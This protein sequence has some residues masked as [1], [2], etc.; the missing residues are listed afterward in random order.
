MCSLDTVLGAW[1]RLGALATASSY[2]QYNLICQEGFLSRVIVTSV[3]VRK[4]GWKVKEEAT[5]L[6]P[7]SRVAEL[8]RRVMVFERDYIVFCFP[9]RG[10]KTL[11]C[12]CSIWFQSRRR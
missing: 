8:R 12:Q 3:P 6:V 1:V 9:V 2:T 7:C 4:R 5:D 11:M 10:V